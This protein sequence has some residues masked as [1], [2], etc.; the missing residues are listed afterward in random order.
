MLTH[1]SSSSYVSTASGL[2]TPSFVGTCSVG[3]STPPDDPNP[4]AG[5]T[6]TRRRPPAH[7]AAASHTGRYA[8]TMP[9]NEALASPH[10]L[11]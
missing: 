9:S 4:S 11:S 6:T 1:C 10:P 8:V 5:G 3:R 7:A 2:M